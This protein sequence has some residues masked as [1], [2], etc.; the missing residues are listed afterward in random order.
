MNEIIYKDYP[1]PFGVL[2][3]GEMN[4]EICLCDWKFRKMRNSINNRIEKFVG[5]NEWKKGNTVALQK[6]E[7]WLDDYFDGKSPLPFSNFL[8]IGTEFQKRVWES[9][10]KIPYGQTRTYLEL[11]RSTFSENSVRAVAAANGANSLS[12]IIP[13]HR[14]I[15][16]NKKL[17]GYAGGLNA[18]KK[19]L[20]LENPMFQNQMVLF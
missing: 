5:A 2:I 16:S 10:L 6:I 8:M 3:L 7:N 17:V 14:V 19:L 18:K 4:G 9:L 1:S 11:S 15:G 12:I 20:N 13:C